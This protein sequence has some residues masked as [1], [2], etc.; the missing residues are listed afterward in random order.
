MNIARL[1]V[2]TQD[3]AHVS[4]AEQAKV[5][6]LGGVRWIQ[7]RTKI[8]NQEEI[9]LQAKEVVEMCRFFNAT[10][11]INDHIHLVEELQADGVHLGQTDMS[12]I[13]ARK[14]L[15][16]AY[17]I[18]GTTNTLEDIWNIF[19]YV[20]YMGL[21]PYAFTKTKKNLSPIL[22][23]EG[24]RTIIQEMDLA[25]IQRPIIAI[26][27]ITLEDLGPLSSTGVHGVAVASVIN[28]N[29]AP[30][31]M[32]TAFEENINKYFLKENQ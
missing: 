5:A 15:G 28:E 29:I 20:D 30:T 31:Q 2:I 22:G 32:A 9:I 4:H 10:C 26:G 1:Q 25:G 18:G 3:L 11:I 6:C 27:G 7:Y 24:Y 8:S 12:I 13:E 14:L 23:L 16:D 19:P 17:I 21:G